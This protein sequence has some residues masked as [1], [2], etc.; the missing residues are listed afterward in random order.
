MSY[1]RC[2]KDSDVYMYGAIG[3]YQIFT[4]GEFGNRSYFHDNLLDCWKTLKYLEKDGLKVPQH[5]YDRIVGELW[6]EF[7]MIPVYRNDWTC[8]PFYK[9][10]D[11][12]PLKVI[13]DWF[14]D[15]LG[16]DPL[17]NY[18]GD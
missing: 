7:E 5:T 16:Y 8:M 11:G 15:V 10:K 2:T 14:V 4:S 1:C 13:C 9:F 17:K 3:G 12:T 6:K 18:K